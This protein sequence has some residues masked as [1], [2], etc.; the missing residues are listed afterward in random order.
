MIFLG[1]VSVA[2]ASPL[3][4]YSSVPSSSQQRQSLYIQGRQENVLRPAA[5]NNYLCSTSFGRLLQQSVEHDMVVGKTGSVPQQSVP[6]S[7]QQGNGTCYF[8]QAGADHGKS[9]I[10][11]QPTSHVQLTQQEISSMLGAAQNSSL[12]V[13]SVASQLSVNQVPVTPS[14][15]HQAELKD[16]TALLGIPSKQSLAISVPQGKEI[17]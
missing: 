15:Q 12:Q 1:T 14:V 3:K 7:E 13:S 17:S 9:A 4:D 6:P 10:G 2:A 11:Q 8:T 16:G 5:D